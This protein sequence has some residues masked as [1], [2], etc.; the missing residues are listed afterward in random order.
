[1]VYFLLHVAAY[2]G[3]AAWQL[4]PCLHVMLKQMKLGNHHVAVAMVG[5]DASGLV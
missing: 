2:A 5:R 4:R 1:M 3:E